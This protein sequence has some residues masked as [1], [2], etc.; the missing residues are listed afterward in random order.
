MIRICDI[1]PGDPSIDEDDKT[2]SESIITIEDG[3]RSMVA[4]IESK[5]DSVN[6]DIHLC[7]M[8]SRVALLLICPRCSSPETYNTD[9][10]H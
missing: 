8:P 7:H 9:C 10:P 5:S 2:E 3:D 6:S 4:K 1:L